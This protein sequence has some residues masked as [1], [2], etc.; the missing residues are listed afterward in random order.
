[1][2]SAP[3]LDSLPPVVRPDPETRLDQLL[4]EYATV[5]PL[6]D[7]YAAQIKAITDGIKSELTTLHPE[8]T[9]IM[10]VGDALANPLRLEAV[11][12]WRIDTPRLKAEKPELYVRFAKQSTTWRLSQVKQS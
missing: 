2:T 5:K 11:Q 4:A 8:R 3:Q 12:Q 6:A 10:V 9:E 1:M 7:K